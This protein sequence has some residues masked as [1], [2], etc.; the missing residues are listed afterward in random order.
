MQSINIAGGWI[1]IS[2]GVLSGLALMPVFLKDDIMG[3]Y[4][5]FRRRFT[6]LGHIAFVV[7]GVINIMC[8]LMGQGDNWGLLAGAI[9]MSAGC[10]I[11]AFWEP[12]KFVLVIPA[13]MILYAC[14]Q[15]ARISWPT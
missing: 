13:L 1:L 4:G 3:G 10:L 12:F 9:G 2:T 15:L 5:S 14:I 6:R 11:S 7:L 8:G